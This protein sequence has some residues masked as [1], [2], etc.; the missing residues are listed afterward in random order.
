[1]KRDLDTEAVR[2]P[3]DKQATAAPQAYGAVIYTCPMH[4]EVRQDH[5]GPC[6]KCGM[7]LETATPIAGGH[8]TDDAEGAELRDMTRRFW[9]GAVLTLPV[10]LLAMSH[11]IPALGRQAWLDSEGV[12]L[13]RVWPT[14]W[15]ASSCLW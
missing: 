6:P 15:P 13:A 3:D 7:T 12:R 10:F 11:L 5:P 1:M 9:I 14:R 4:P 2:D 8:A